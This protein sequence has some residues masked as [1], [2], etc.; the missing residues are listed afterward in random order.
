V[1]ATREKLVLESPAKINLNLE[2]LGR[3]GDGYHSIR[4]VLVPI[5][6][7][8]TVTFTP[9]GR[10]LV[11]HGGQGTPK[12]EGNLAYEAVKALSRHAGVRRGLDLRIVKRI[13]IAA[14]LG[15]G[16][17]NAATVLRGLNDLWELGLSGTELERIGLELGSDVPFFLR[18][19]TCIARGR[20]EDLERIPRRTELELVLVH[21]PVKVTSEWAYGNI[22]DE[23]TR[24]GSSTSM[25][26]VALASGRVELVAKHLEN[27]L[28][29]GV[30]TAHKDVRDIAKKLK[31]AGALGVLMSGSGPTVFGLAADAESADG[32]AAKLS[33]SRWKVIRARAVEG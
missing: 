20:G 28:E 1:P 14:G 17:S 7:H 19:G 24:S 27:D 18:G 26:K 6:L 10:K 32:I 12:G 3:R 33:G 30:R 11:F 13:P 21:P 2:V 9:G 25:I 29:P 5:S 4:S 31:S 22:P 16:S 8:D 23:L 15:G